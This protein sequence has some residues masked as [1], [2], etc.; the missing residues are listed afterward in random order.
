MSDTLIG[1]PRLRTEPTT[2]A[3]ALTG[4]RTGNFSLCMMTP[5]LLSHTGQGWM[6]TYWLKSYLRL[7]ELERACEGQRE[8]VNDWDFSLAKPWESLLSS[9]LGTSEA[10]VCELSD[11]AAGEAMKKIKSILSFTSLCFHLCSSW[12]HESGL[13][14]QIQ[15]W[16]FFS[17]HNCNHQFVCITSIYFTDLTLNIHRSFPSSSHQWYMSSWTSSTSLEN[18]FS[19]DDMRQV[20]ITDAQHIDP[21]VLGDEQPNCSCSCTSYHS[22]SDTI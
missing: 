15:M 5:N 11:E 4:S 21:V 9:T 18:Q 2:Q 13:W 19:H 10:C 16:C 8:T 7:G 6:M 14:L 3:C 12:W 17:C 20:H 22:G 1:C